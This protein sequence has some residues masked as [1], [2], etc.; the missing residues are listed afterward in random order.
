MGKKEDK[1]FPLTSKDN[2]AIYLNRIV[3]SCEICMD[4]LKNT[5]QREV[6]YL[7]NMQVRVSCHMKCMLKC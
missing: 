1:Q 6:N 7:R 5:T 4:R 2:C 3:S